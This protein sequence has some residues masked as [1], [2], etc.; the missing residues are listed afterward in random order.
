MGLMLTSDD[1]NEIRRIVR[2]ELRKFM[3]M[4]SRAETELAQ[5]RIRTL[6]RGT[7]GGTLERISTTSGNEIIETRID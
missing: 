5:G 3:K 6:I 7:N 1:Q 2:E 4:Q